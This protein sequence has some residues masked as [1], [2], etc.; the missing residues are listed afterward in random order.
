MQRYPLFDA[1]EISIPFTTVLKDAT[2]KTTHSGS[3]QIGI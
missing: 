1:L 2:W 3:E